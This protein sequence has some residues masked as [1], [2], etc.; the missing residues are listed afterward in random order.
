MVDARIAR[1]LQIGIIRLEE[2]DGGLA[3]P[4]EW[5]AAT[6]ERH[7][8]PLQAKRVAKELARRVDSAGG[9]GELSFAIAKQALSLT[10][11]DGSQK[12]YSGAHGLLFS[13]GNGGDV[14]VAVTI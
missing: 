6:F 7:V 10:T 4:E 2:S 5:N 12:L 8:P 13:R 9:E 1:F 11:A 14:R 3:D